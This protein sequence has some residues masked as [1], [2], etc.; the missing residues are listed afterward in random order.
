MKNQIPHRF[1]QLIGK[2]IAKIEYL[3]NE[4]CNELMWHSKP[5]VIVFTDGT[6][7]IPV[8]DEEGNDGGAMWHEHNGAVTCIH[9]ETVETIPDMVGTMDQLN[10]LTIQE[11]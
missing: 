1:K 6:C 5:V 4:E 3:S 11:G 9:T 2:T 10:S 8:R 7:L